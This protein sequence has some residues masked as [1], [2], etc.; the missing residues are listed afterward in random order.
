VAK[1]AA[2][3]GVAGSLI[4]L[5]DGLLVASKIPAGL[6]ADTVAGFLPQIYGK[7]S[8]CTKELRMG[9]LNNLKFTVGR[10]PWRIY[11]VGA[12]FFAAF[13]REGERMPASQLAALA[14][15]LDRNP[16]NAR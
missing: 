16:Q 13:G 15:E 7:V 6:N 12:I 8:S 9:E 3:P 4:T 10:V 11:R 2:L 1:A 5:P 14:C